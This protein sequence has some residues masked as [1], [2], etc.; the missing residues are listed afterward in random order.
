MEMNW[1][2]LVLFYIFANATAKLLQKIIVSNENVD[3][4]AFSIVIQL[5][6]GL[7][8]VP[9]IMVQPIKYPSLPIAWI[10]LLVSCLGYASC[11]ALYFYSMKRL[12]ISQVE[13]IGTTRSVWL[14]L[15]GIIAF[16]EV[17]TV[18]KMI[19]V[20]LIMAAIIMIYARKGSLIGLGKNHFA[21]LLYAIIIS[22]SYALDKYALGYFSITL[23]QALVFTVPA[24]ITAIIFPASVKKIIP[25]FQTKRMIILITAGSFFQA[26]S[27]L[28][29]YRA[30]QLGGQLSIVGPIA[31]TTTVVTISAGI[32]LLHEHWNIKRK[33]LGILLALLGVLF[34][35]VI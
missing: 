30:Y 31:Q 22:I 21:V 8:T 27:V 14:M 23:Y 11:M 5:A 4:I 24:C 26:A 17:M 28:A 32:L 10:A 3:E 1:F 2:P 20:C 16:G 6:P 9:L 33:L 34:L 12:E 18:S 35:R 13:T 7:L 29:L 15:L 25:M 19:G